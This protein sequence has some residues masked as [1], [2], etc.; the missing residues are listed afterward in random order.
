MRRKGKEESQDK[1]S[2]ENQRQKDRESTKDHQA[3]EKS[4][5]YFARTI[6]YKESHPLGKSRDSVIEEGGGVGLD[7]GV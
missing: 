1:K 7:I 4:K 6:V 5:Q 2:K 3:R